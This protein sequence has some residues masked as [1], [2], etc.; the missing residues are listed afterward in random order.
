M[1]TNLGFS[2]QRVIVSNC[3]YKS[4]SRILL[5]H[6]K[7]LFRQNFGLDELSYDRRVTFLCGLQ[8]LH[9]A[10]VDTVVNR[11]CIH[12]FHINTVLQ[13]LRIN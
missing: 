1:K 9:H 5:R 12:L 3:F 2:V 4:Q 6:S 10:L 8:K 11:L 7:R 13:Q